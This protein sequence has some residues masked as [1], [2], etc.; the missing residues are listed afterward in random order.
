MARGV[1]P[2]QVVAVVRNRGRA[3]SLAGRGVRVRAADYSRPETLGAALAGVNRLLLV[4]SSELGQLAAQ[5]SNVITA[6]R[7]AGVSRIAYTSMLNADDSTSPLASE[8]RDTERMLREAGV[9]YTLLRNGYYTEIYTDPLGQ[10]LQAGEILGAAGR[11]KIAAATRS[12]YATAA[13][14]ALLQDDDG[15]RTYELGGPAFGLPQ[16]AQVISEVTGTKV[17][18]RDLP[19][20]EYAGALHRTG[21]DEATARFVAAL[22]ASIAR[23]DL[24]TSSQDLARLLGRPATPLSEVVRPA[25]DLFKVNSQTAV[26]GLIG[27]GNIGSTVARLAIGAG[28]KVVLSNGRGPETLAGLIQQLGPQARA[29]TPAEAA[30]SGDIVVVTIP[31][32]AY[33]QV[34]VEPLAGKV[35]IDTT[36]Y[37]PDRDGHV[38]ELDDQNTTSSEL[39]QAHLP[40]SHVVKAFNTIFFKHLAALGQPHEATDRSALPIAGDD[41]TAKTTVTAFL[42]AIGYDTYDAGPLSEGWRLQPGTIAYAY[43]TDGSFEHPRAA[44]TERLTS[45]LAQAKRY[46]DM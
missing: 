38:A 6:A 42:D 24:E 2:S 30:T 29:A 19:A 21:L 14:A 12:D 34:P 25:H 40:A 28:Y 41:D 32:Q 8:H 36:N 45:L 33:R 7:T 27:A 22:D 10:Y 13:A 3:T 23:G 4:S 26:I 43:S 37:L 18:Y 1:P 31:L 39:L 20:G 35:V 5:H 44:G 9:P 15:N 46:R 11:G 16:L 17:T